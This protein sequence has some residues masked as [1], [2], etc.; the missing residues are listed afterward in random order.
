E[1]EER[2]RQITENVAELIAVLDL[3]G[4]RTYANPAYRGV[5]GET[6]TLVG[7]DSFR[8]I[9]PEDRARVRALFAETVRT[10][11]SR[12][13]EYRFLL[14][15]GTLRHIESQSRALREPG[16][17]IVNVLVVSR[18]VSARREAES[19]LR[20]QASLLDKARDAIIA[21]SLDHRIA[22]WNA[23]AE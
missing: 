10:G 20:E 7:T 4:R 13:A 6:S 3:E 12:Y 2:F 16:G 1:Q 9:H 15:D 21:T 14:A 5:L 18:D 8:E 19:R 17:R 22:Y 23:S 11:E